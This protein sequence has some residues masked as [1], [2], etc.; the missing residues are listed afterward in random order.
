LKSF[1]LGADRDHRA[2]TTGLVSYRRC[3]RD[4]P[5]AR[6]LGAYNIANHEVLPGQ[7]LLKI[8]PIGNI[9]ASAIA[10]IPRNSDIAAI[11][12]KQQNVADVVR[13][14]LFDLA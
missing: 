5:F 1:E 12:S 10:G 2:Q 3:Q 9:K 14:L 11:R 7:R 6:E 4:H 8:A 13:Q